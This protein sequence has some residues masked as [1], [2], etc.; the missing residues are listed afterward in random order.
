MDIINRLKQFITAQGLSSTQF[1]DQAGIPRPSVSQI[2]NGRNKKISNELLEKIHAAYP[3]LD[4]MW[5]LFGEGSLSASENLLYDS[6]LT[7][8]PEYPNVGKHE[9]RHEDEGLFSATFQDESF[10]ETEKIFYSQSNKTVDPI[11]EYGA[12]NNSPS[13]SARND[14]DSRPEYGARQHLKPE[15]LHTAV[16]R[17][18]GTESRLTRRIVNIYVFY[19]DGS[20]EVLKPQG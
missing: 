20:Y 10:G 16:Q 12:S 18:G 13:N 4:I 3:S 5:L 6:K 7:S 1:A 8:A 15:P 17:E 19:D 2:L 14:K 11:V 9:E